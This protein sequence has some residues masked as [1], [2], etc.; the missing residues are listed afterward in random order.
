[1]GLDKHMCDMRKLIR[2]LDLVQVMGLSGGSP[3]RVRR[4]AAT[5]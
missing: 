4:C 5:V 2:F 3:V 1:M